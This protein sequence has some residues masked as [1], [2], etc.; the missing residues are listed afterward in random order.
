MRSPWF[1]AWPL[2]VFV[3]WLALVYGPTLATGG[4]LAT[5]DGLGYYLPARAIAAAAVLAGEG[6]F[7]N[8]FNFGGVPLLAA[9]QGGVFFPAN[10]G[11]LLLPPGPAMA[12][13]VLLGYLGAGGATYLYGRALGLPRVAACLAG[14]SFMGGGYMV[15]HL[16]HVTMLHGAALLPAM[17]WALERHAAGG[18]A[19][20]L[21]L[22][23]LFVALQV[24]AGYPQT[25]VV[26]LLLT[27]AYALWRHGARP[28]PLLALAAAVGLGLGLAAVQW[29]P[30]TAM[31]A[32][33]PRQHMAYADLVA[34]S[35]PPRQL[36]TLF[37][38]FLFG[39]EP[40][41]L[42]TTPYWGAGP[43]QNELVGYMG[44][45]PPMLAGAAWGRWHG[46]P[47]RGHPGDPVRFWV[48]AGG[49]ALV[50]ALGSATPLYRLWAAVPG[51]S[52]VRVPGRHLLE[53]DLAVA[54][55]AGL[56]LAFLLEAEPAVRRRWAA[57]GGGAVAAALVAGWLAVALLGP[58]LAA[59]WQPLMPRGVDLAAALS[60][61]APAVWVP[62]ATGLLSLAVLAALVRHPGRPA[63]AALV[64]VALADLGLFGQ[65]QGWRQLCPHPAAG[66]PL[67][68]APREGGR[69]L[70]IDAAGYPFHDYARMQALGYPQLG[71]LWGVRAVG[72]YEPLLPA[73]Y[74]RLVGGMGLAG[75]VSDPTLFAPAH[76]A[77]DL[78]ACTELRVDPAALAQPAWHAALAT[79]RWTPT[80]RVP[81]VMRFANA[82]ALPA[83]W[84]PAA[85]ATLAE[86]AV[87]ERV[88]GHVAWDPAALALVDEGPTPAAS[89]GTARQGARGF[90]WLELE[91]TGAAPG[92]VV[93]SEGY[94]PGWQATEDGHTLAVRRVDGLLLGVEVPAGAHRVRLS[95]APPRWRAGL[96]LS[97]ASALL[98]LGW[99]LTT[100][101]REPA[102]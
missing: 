15:A 91:T 33:S 2:L 30:G 21:P 14:A 63:V 11:F 52:I 51:L 34:T 75:V 73:R 31:L 28:R 41:A 26:S 18:S 45:L 62:L 84:R 67:P 55:L 66:P 23:A 88:V 79:P 95:Y 3:G 100:R 38:P 94:D 16:E 50:L 82:R 35:L 65:C 8:P 10:W 12:L 56:G 74:A 32:A 80:G 59:H 97:L 54:V 99:A 69:V 49:V 47:E 64:L 13:A 71:A 70:A 77:L 89:A 6:P 58:R 61:W 29:L 1:C 81:E 40:S 27:G 48:P 98:A 44:L 37:F 78:L 96:A 5:G 36:A 43:W 24:F 57:R 102:A 92:L 42:F 17:L 83:A 25:V 46:A 72:G 7:W 93:A 39:A 4:L 101:R 86:A 85:A 20:F 76:H 9:F 90:G 68:A 87:D 19:R 22:F 53:L 60:P